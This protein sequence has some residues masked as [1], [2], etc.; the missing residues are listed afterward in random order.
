MSPEAPSSPHFWGFWLPETIP[1][2]ILGLRNLKYWVLGPSGESL[3]HDSLVTI[4]RK[5]P[6]SFYARPT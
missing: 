3:P 5:E 6:V 4:I 1:I 2:K